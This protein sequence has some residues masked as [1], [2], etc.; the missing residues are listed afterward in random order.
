MGRAADLRART[1]IAVHADR[2]ELALAELHRTGWRVARNSKA[3]GASNDMHHAKLAE[4]NRRAAL[5]E[6]EAALWRATAEVLRLDRDIRREQ[7][8]RAGIVPW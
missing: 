5:A 8:Q 6:R 7:A 1:V 4:A 2:C 3:R